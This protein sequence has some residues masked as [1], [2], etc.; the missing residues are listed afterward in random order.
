MNDE[1][2]KTFTDIM[3][4]INRNQREIMKNLEK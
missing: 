3:D 2:K 4:C 1:I